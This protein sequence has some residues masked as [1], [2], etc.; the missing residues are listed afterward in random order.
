MA[1]LAD[2]GGF[3]RL[4]Q[5]F[6]G[7]LVLLLGDLHAAIWKDARW[8]WAGA[9]MRRL[10]VTRF[11]RRPLCEPIPALGATRPKDAQQRHDSL[12]CLVRDAVWDVD[13]VRLCAAR[14]AIEA[15]DKGGGVSARVVDETGFP[16]PGKRSV[17]AHRQDRGT[18][19]KIANCQIGVSHSVAT[20]HEP[21][22]I[23][24]APCAPSRCHSRRPRLIRPRDRAHTLAAHPAASGRD[25]GA[26]RDRDASAAA[27]AR[28]DTRSSRPPTASR[29]FAPWARKPR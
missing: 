21:V 13:A 17:G 6:D 19:G 27:S 29:A 1:A 15:L 18:Q 4:R 26:D 25:G 14:E 12:L 7:K 8:S 24:F 9:R 23:D 10:E 3:A 28:S 2:A 5:R 20:E 16:K 22:P 11:L